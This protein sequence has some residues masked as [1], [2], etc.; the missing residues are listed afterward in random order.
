MSHLLGK[1]V[2]EKQKPNVFVTRS[3][4]HRLWYTFFVFG[5]HNLETNFVVVVVNVIFVC[6][7]VCFFR[8][9]EHCNQIIECFNV[10]ISIEIGYSLFEL[11]Y[12]TVMIDTSAF[13]VTKV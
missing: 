1:N 13:I 11:M 4:R 6:L 10:F 9:A 5:L 8:S 7:F 12:D 3:S 2:F